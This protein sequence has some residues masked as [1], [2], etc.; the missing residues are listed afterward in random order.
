MKTLQS[1]LS[2]LTISG[3][4]VPTT[5]ADCPYYNNIKD[6]S[7]LNWT[8]LNMTK[9]K[10]NTQ[11]NQ[12]KHIFKTNGADK[13]TE[14]QIKEKINEL[15]P[16]VNINS[17]NVI[18]I[19]ENSAEITITGFSGKKTINFT[20]NKSVPINKVITNT[21]LGEID[22]SIGG[23]TIKQIVQKSLKLFNPKLDISKINITNISLNS[24][25]VKTNDTSIYTGEIDINYSWP[26]KSVFKNTELGLIRINGVNKPTEQQI[27]EKINELIPQVNINSINV[28]NIS[29]NSAEITITGFSGKKTINFT[30]NKSVPINKVITNTNLGEID[31]SIGGWTIKQIVQES[32]KLFN[33]KLDISKINITNISLNSAKVKTNDTSIYTGEIDI[34]YSRP[35][36][37]VFKNTELGLIRINGVNKPTEQQIKEKINEL[38][39]QVNINSINVINISE[40]S[41][42][43]TITGFSGKK[44]IN[45]TVNKSVPINKVIT[46]TNLGEIDF[47][48][49]GWTIKQIV[50]ESLKLFN[51]KLDIS[52]INIT[53]ISLNSA[54]VKT[55]D[56]SIYTGE[57]DIN[58]SRPVKSVFKNTE[59]GLIR[60]NG[61][62]KPTEQQIKEKINE[63]IP[64]VN[65][66]SINVINISENSAEITIT[67][68][69]GKKT[70][71]FTVN[72]SV[73]INK[74][75][76]NTNLGEID[77]SIGGWTIKQIVQESL[78]LFNPK[79]DISKI[80]I[81]NISLN[82]AKVKTNDTSIYTGE[83]D[84]NYSRPVKS[85][86]K[87]TE[88]GLIRINGV[89]KPTEQQIKEKINEL[90][91]QVNINS[92]NVINISENSAEIT[93]TGF[94][95][96]K[97]INFTVN[98][99]V[100]INKVITNTNLG[101][102]DFSIGGWT[103]K[104]IV[105]ESLKLFNPKLDISKINITNI[106]LNSAK[107]K[108]NDT[109][110]YTGEIDI[111]YSRPVKSVFKNT[112]LGLIRING[113][114]KPTEQE[115][116]NKIK[117]LN[118]DLENNINDFEVSDITTTNAKI[119]FKRKDILSGEVVVTFTS[120]INLNKII[121][122]N[123][124]GEFITDN[125]SNPTEQQIKNKLKKMYTDLDITKIKVE[126]ITKSSAKITSADETVYTENVKV[127]YTVSIDSL[128]W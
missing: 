56:T 109:S 15:I 85:V 96:K 88:L 30:V 90:I 11:N 93:I 122:N 92:I 102:I 89:N 79:L 19:S 62:N 77:F 59:L 72:K 97:T 61:V 123:N 112:E 120:N 26:V 117:E 14:Q 67:G 31:F 53:N 37:S 125:L 86:F 5:I 94:S 75:I 66:N 113:V 81:T 29:E 95:G 4:A 45:F 100:P 119:N 12:T 44:T 7:E 103:I 124:L 42:E 2:V 106:S 71:N 82:S 74:V 51:P 40:N 10:R 83:I 105:Q 54:K 91:P 116:K 108:T 52:K 78:K 76:T 69:S 32:L 64:Q 3:T 27:K 28:I 34:N 25:K 57:I 84:I 43:I 68:F 101:E 128:N 80:N 98:K 21:N 23:W 1:L 63:L 99:S 60:I 58:Y 111:N 24:A 114:N 6:L 47:S 33:P 20:V 39:P 49:G 8:G 104:Q 110:I 48:I 70:I 118:K 55:N 38:I 36:K 87:N 127:N 41:A 73:P 107:V 9:N 35:V 17:I 22:F 115:I 18:N 16:Q 46:N 126:N 50:Q 121:T 13:P 65:I